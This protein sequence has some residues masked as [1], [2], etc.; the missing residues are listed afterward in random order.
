MFFL[1]A[2]RKRLQFL[3]VMTSLSV[4]LDVKKN[5]WSELYLKMIANGFLKKNMKK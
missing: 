4:K 2:L 1:L 3:L 5:V